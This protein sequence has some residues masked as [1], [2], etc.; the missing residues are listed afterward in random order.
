MGTRLDLCGS[1][2]NKKALPTMENAKMETWKISIVTLKDVPDIFP[3]DYGD[4]SNKIS[5]INID[6]L[7]TTFKI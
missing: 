2:L 6:K 7:F 3:N 1:T 4:I 5:T